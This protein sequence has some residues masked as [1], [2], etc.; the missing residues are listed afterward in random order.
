M[1]DAEFT[2]Y[3]M[4]NCIKPGVGFPQIGHLQETDTFDLM[5]TLSWRTAEPVSVVCLS[6]SQPCYIFPVVK[7]VKLKFHSWQENLSDS[8]QHRRRFQAKEGCGSTCFSCTWLPCYLPKCQNAP[9]TTATMVSQTNNPGSSLLP[10]SFWS[11]LIFHSGTSGSLNQRACWHSGRLVEREQ[12]CK[13]DRRMQA[14]LQVQY[15]VDWAINVLSGN[16]A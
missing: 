15:T 12:C 1:P 7:D 6:V 8:A 4:W 3:T 2:F 9:L 13:G 5:N 11:H 14:T 16:G 10:M